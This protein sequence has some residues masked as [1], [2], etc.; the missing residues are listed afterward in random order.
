MLSQITTCLGSEAVQ[1]VLGGASLGASKRVEGEDS[2]GI[3]GDQE[4]EREVQVA[5]E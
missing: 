4:R 3:K 2:S 1:A 5:A